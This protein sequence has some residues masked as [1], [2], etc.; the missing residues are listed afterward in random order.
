[1]ELGRRAAILTNPDGS[2]S[3]P[4]FPQG[5][6]RARVL[7]LETIAGPKALVLQSA[8]GWPLRVW[9]DRSYRP[10]QSTQWKRER[11]VL[12]WNG[13]LSVMFAF[14]AG[15]V[16]ATLGWLP[17]RSIRSARRRFRGQCPDCG[18]SR[19]GLTLADRCPECGGC[20]AAA[21]SVRSRLE[22]GV[23]LSDEPHPSE[24]RDGQPLGLGEVDE[25]GFTEQEPPTEQAMIKARIDAGTWNNPT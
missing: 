22:A 24:V 23:P 12:W 19:E 20:G 15:V 4:P 2:P 16:T 8:T 25:E 14:V 10:I 11:Q 7:E 5:P 6:G 18:Y 1:M 9:V 17:L 13:L 3:Y 21:T